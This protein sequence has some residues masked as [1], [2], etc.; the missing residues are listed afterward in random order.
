MEQWL[1][2]QRE[3]EI[4]KLLLPKTS[5][6]KVKSDQKLTIEHYGK[7][8][9]H[10]PTSTHYPQGIRSNETGRASVAQRESGVN[11]VVYSQ[12]V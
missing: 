8:K 12:G 3:K 2:Y 4:R 1:K 5:R 10:H 11:C 7:F 9:C 6:V